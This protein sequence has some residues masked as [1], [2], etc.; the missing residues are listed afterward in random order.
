LNYYIVETLWSVNGGIVTGTA[1]E[2]PSNHLV[3]RNDRALSSTSPHEV[4]HCLDLYHTHETAFGTENINGSNC[5]SAGDLVCDTPADPRLG[6][7]NVN[8]N[9]E[10]VGGGGFNP[11]TDNVMSYSRG[12]C[13]DSFTTLQGSRMRQALSQNPILSSIQSSVC[14]IPNL[15][16]SYVICNSEDETYTLEDGGNNVTWQT[17]SNLQ[18]LSSNNNSI[19]VEAINSSVNESAFIEAILPFETERINLWIGKPI[20]NNPSIS[21]LS[22]VDCSSTY[23]F[24][25][26]GSVS[27]ATNTRWVVSPQFDDVSNINDYELFVDPTNG[28]SG[29]VTFVASNKCGETIICKPVEVNGHFCGAAYI[30]FPNQYSCTSAGRKTTRYYSI[31]PNPANNKL[32]IEKKQTTNQNTSSSSE[33]NNTTYELFDFNS[34]LQTSGNFKDKIDLNLS[35]YKK[36]KY[37]LKITSGKNSEA[38]HIILN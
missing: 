15:T 2:I 38:H 29:Y 30:N 4:G 37:I 32:T 18:I 27:G 19:T 9:C 26:T 20:L 7:N 8:F 3:I 6:S 12:L 21:G 33:D 25:Y 22:S 1:V 23:I 5:S 28:G 10:Y 35:S 16:G 34:I 24:D 11:L 14:A 36:G 31:Y 13:R 17:S